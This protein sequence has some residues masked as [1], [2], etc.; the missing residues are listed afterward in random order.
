MDSSHIENWK[1]GVLENDVQTSNTY[2][3]REGCL[4]LCKSKEFVMAAQVN[5][6]GGWKCHCGNQDSAER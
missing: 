1:I 6:S 3:L 2:K 5:G 4:G